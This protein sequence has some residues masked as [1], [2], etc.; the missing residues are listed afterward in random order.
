MKEPLLITQEDPEGWELTPHPLGLL[1]AARQL[2]SRKGDW[3][4]PPASLLGFPLLPQG[5]HL[6]LGCKALGL[7]V[8]Q[9]QHRLANESQTLGDV[10]CPPHRSCPNLWGCGGW[11]C[12]RRGVGASE[13]NCMG[14]VTALASSQAGPRTQPSPSPGPQAQEARAAH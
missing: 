10:P 14:F 4:V 11:R 7:A 8:H 9:A 6:A 3:R 13:F 2:A 1:A 5:W 12:G